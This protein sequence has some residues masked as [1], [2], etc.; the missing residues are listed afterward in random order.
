MGGWGHINNAPKFTR[1]ATGKAGVWAID[2]NK[3]IHYRYGYLN[4]AM[5]NMHFTFV[6]VFEIYILL[7][8]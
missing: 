1:V 3:L 5:L 4:Y 8:F 2:S 6:S 7:T